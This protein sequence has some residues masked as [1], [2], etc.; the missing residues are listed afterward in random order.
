VQEQKDETDTVKNQSQMDIL[1]Q[2]SFIRDARRALSWLDV[3]NKSEDFKNEEVLRK[4]TI[5][6]HGIKSS[7]WN[8]GEAALAE[9]AYKLEDSARAGD[10]EQIL[11]SIPNFTA[12]LR[13]LVERLESNQVEYEAEEDSGDL[14]VK[15]Q[16]VMEMCTFYNRK[17][18]LD[19]LSDIKKCS[20][21]TKD[22]V[23][24]IKEYVLH[25]DFEEAEAVAMAYAD[26]LAGKNEVK[27]GLLNKEIDGLDIKKG[28]ERYDGDEKTYLMLLR[29][30]VDSV[31]SML[32]TI[33]TVSGENLANYRIKVHGIKG[34]SLDIFAE[35]IGKEAKKLED[36]AKTG[37][38]NYIYSN[39]VSFLE[40]TKKLVSNIEKVLSS[41]E[42]ENPKARKDKPDK[43]TLLKL[44][45]ACKNYDINEA[46]K[47]MADIEKYQYES[48]G[49]LADW[50]ERS[51]AIMNFS[52][53]VEKL[54]ELEEQGGLC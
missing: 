17:G 31:N 37:D 4:F 38:L 49:G 30:Y 39:N 26:K 48:D 51:I 45:D 2:E 6:I 19:I 46:D 11:S 25:S 12:E 41:I 24:K 21:E 28:L 34:T 9:L 33:E 18:A 32:K 23:N 54:T 8:I 3:H 14:L 42:A 44:L 35:Q 16:A 40:K 47:A 5:I 7:L 15:M 22:V 20:K 43:E 36:A 29:S 1:L 50:L 27:G 13:G 53:I 52:Q 10:I